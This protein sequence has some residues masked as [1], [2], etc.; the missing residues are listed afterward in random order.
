MYVADNVVD[1]VF[2]DYDFG[3]SRFDELFFEFFEFGGYVDRADFGTGHDAVAYLYFGKV[4]GVLEYF[5]IVVDGL[6]IILCVFYGTL[7]EM[8]QL[9]FAECGVACLLVYFYIEHAQYLA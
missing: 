7:D 9:H 8:C 3:V 4:E 5:Y 6:F 1:V 2:V